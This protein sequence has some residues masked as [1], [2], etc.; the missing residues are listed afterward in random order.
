MKENKEQTD[1]AKN[2]MAV[3]CFAAKKISKENPSQFY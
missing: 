1:Q 3:T 2:I